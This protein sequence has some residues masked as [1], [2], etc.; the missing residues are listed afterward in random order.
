[1]KDVAKRAGVSI[2]TVSFVINETKPI[3]AATKLRVNKAIEELGFRRNALASALAS[4]RSHLIALL[5]PAWEH[6]LGGTSMRF[7]AGAVNAAK[8]RG[9]TL[10]LWPVNND[11]AQLKDFLSN[12]LVEGVVLMEVQLSDVRVE[13]LA[14]MDIPFALI[15]RTR[16][17]AT[18]SY[19]DVD[20]EATVDEALAHLRSLGHR[21]IALVLEEFEDDSMAGYAPPVRLEAAYRNSMERSGGEALVFHC[22]NTPA[23]GRKAAEELL[24]AAPW[25]TAVLIDNE[26]G[27]FGLVSRLVHAGRRVPEDVSVISLMTTTEMASLADPILTTMNAPAEELGRMGVGAVIDQIEGASQELPQVLVACTLHEGE[28]TGAARSSLRA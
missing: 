9:Y 7:V 12:G 2:A 21:D 16:N 20:Y 22:P 23:G 4:K 14:S 3:S 18:L 11:G 24:S 1:M 5:F 13:V 25:T 27:S 19:V 17:P 28:S 10:L 6:R 8:E 15:G 26:E